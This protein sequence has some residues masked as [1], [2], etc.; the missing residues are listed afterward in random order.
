[1]LNPEPAL[2]TVVDVLNLPLNPA[3]ANVVEESP[4]SFIV[5]GL[6]N[7]VAPPDGQLVYYRT[8]EGSLTPAWRLET[9]L[10]DSWLTT[11]IQAEGGNDILA[12]TDYVA[13]NS[14]EVL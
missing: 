7:V 1:M 5:Q 10:D 2:E 14:Y 4:T 8:A 6:S 11:Y 3:E 12:V 9:D 13:D